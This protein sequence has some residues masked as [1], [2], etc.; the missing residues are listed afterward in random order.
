MSYYDYAPY[1]SV[2][3]KR[4]KAEVKLAK[5]RK[6]NPS[7]SPV[8]LNGKKISSSFWGKAWCENLERY[9]DYEHR[10]PRGRS[11]VRNSAVLDLQVKPGEITALVEG[12]ETYKVSVKISTVSASKWKLICQDCSGSVSSLVELLQGKLSSNVMERVCRKEEGLFPS[13]PEIKLSCSCPDWADMCKHVAAAMYGVGA[14]LDKQPDLLFTLRGARANDLIAGAGKSLK[15]S[16]D[17]TRVLEDGDVAALFGLDMEE[18]ALPPLP[19]AK[20]KPTK[21]KTNPPPKK[22]VSMK[23]TVSAEKKKQVKKS[24]PKKSK[25]LAKVSSRSKAI[26]PTKKNRARI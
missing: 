11:Y 26:A 14:R 15:T 20:K 10:L 17:S 6:N 25:T 2:A 13:P 1:V 23:K 19:T 4:K 3:E 12:S 22:A 7:L 5:L 16:A 21:T 8:V 9:R 18:E 24:P